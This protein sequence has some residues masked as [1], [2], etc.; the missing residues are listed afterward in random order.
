VHSDW[1]QL[2]EEYGIVG[3]VLFLVATGCIFRLILRGWRQHS[4]NLCPDGNLAGVNGSPLGPQC[5]AML[6]GILALTAMGF[7]SFGDFNLQMPATTWVL[8]MMTAIALTAVPRE[9]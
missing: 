6:A 8:T 4:L 3:L 5:W 2:L 9:A 7:H 1:V